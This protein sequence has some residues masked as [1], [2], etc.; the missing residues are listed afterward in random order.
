[1]N[2]YNFPENPQFYGRRR[3]RKLSNSSQLA[4]QE[5]KTSESTIANSFKFAVH[6]DKKPKS[7]LVLP[8]QSSDTSEGSVFPTNLTFSR[9]NWDAPQTVTVSGVSHENDSKLDSK[10]QNYSISLGPA[11]SEDL[12][13]SE[14]EESLSMINVDSTN[15]TFEISDTSNYLIT[16][17]ASG[18]NKRD[19]FSIKLLVQPTSNVILPLSSS[20]T[21]EGLVVGSSFSLGR[22]VFFGYRAPALICRA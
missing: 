21:T 9:T 13:Y 18:D 11:I 17:E 16:S 22:V 12:D 7:D 4:I 5:G 1:M 15:G 14:M 20:D 10:D 8:I 2:T 6:L 19:N 3:G